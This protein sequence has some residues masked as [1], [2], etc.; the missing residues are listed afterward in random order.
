MSDDDVNKRT[1]TSV[2]TSTNYVFIS[3]KDYEASE[4]ISVDIYNKI[5][6]YMV[7]NDHGTTEKNLKIN[8][9][10]NEGIAG[11]NYQPTNLYSGRTALANTVRTTKEAI[12][13][14]EN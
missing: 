14:K 2:Q 4:A 1:Q 6:D 11:R 12:E 10:Q 9:V 7:G 5:E 13:S 8:A 3:E